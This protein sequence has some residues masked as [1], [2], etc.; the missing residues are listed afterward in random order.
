VLDSQTW[1]A[2]TLI[3]LAGI[4]TEHL[5]EAEYARVVVLRFAELLEPAEVCL[6]LADDR[7][8]LKIAAASTARTGGLLSAAERHDDGPC[9]RCRQARRPVLNQSL[10]GS[11]G[12]QERARKV[13]FQHVSALPLRHD[14]L[15]V[16]AVA[17]LHRH[18]LDATR[19]DMAELLAAAA[20][21]AI[22]QQRQLHL[23]EVKVGQLQRALDSRVVIEQAK[24]SVAARLGITPSEAFELM[25][26][27]ARRNNLKLADVC[28]EAIRG[29]L[30]PRI[31]GP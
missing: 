29:D 8:R 20:A 23:T 28:A 12:Y 6:M 26:G 5:G 14:S 7:D 19:A 1:L 2:R 3:E 17:V 13:G 10:T 4:G 24:G 9:A 22:V 11:G 16:G 21:I 15:A 31:L 27:H 25:R 18:P 30:T